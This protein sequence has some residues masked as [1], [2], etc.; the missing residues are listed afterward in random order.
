MAFGGPITE[1]GTALKITELSGTRTSSPLHLVVESGQGLGGKALSF[2]RPVSVSNYFTSDG[3]THPYDHA[4]RPEAIET[5][6]ALPVM[7]NRRPRALVYLATRTQVVLGDRWYDS[8]MPLA[9]ELSHKI[10]VE[11][12]VQA[13]LKLIGSDEG[14]P[15]SGINQLDLH[16]IAIELADLAPQVTDETLRRRLEDLGNRCVAGLPQHS[17]DNMV[18]LRQREIDVLREVALGSSNAEAAEALGLLPNTV[19][20]YL[21]SAMAKL[22]AKNR[23]QAVIRA[24][25]LGLV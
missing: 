10:A 15:S 23:I 12:E 3:I 13:R 6:A 16:D 24:Q 18:S 22:H 19:K 14:T 25:E 7:V 20:S 17:V 21:K 4:V 5:L 8:L 2:A 1:R 9:R 11:D